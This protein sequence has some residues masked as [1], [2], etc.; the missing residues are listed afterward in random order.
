M[1]ATDWGDIIQTLVLAAL[2]FILSYI[3]GRSGRR[4]DEADATERYVNSLMKREDE[5][6]DLRAQLDTARAKCTCGSFD[7]DKEK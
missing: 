7:K 6:D 3:F 2:P 1:G 4:K 5:I